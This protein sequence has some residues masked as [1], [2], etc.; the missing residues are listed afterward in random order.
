MSACHQGDTCVNSRWHDVSSTQAVVVILPQRLGATVGGNRIL[1][2]FNN[3]HRLSA[4]VTSRAIAALPATGPYATMKA[5][6][7]IPIHCAFPA[8]TRDN[9]WHHIFSPLRVGT[10]YAIIG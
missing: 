5:R 2:A 7:E 10:S 8:R 4:F 3:A 1:Q 9:G 6:A